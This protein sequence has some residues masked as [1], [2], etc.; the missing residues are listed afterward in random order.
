MPRDWRQL[1]GGLRSGFSGRGA[2]RPSIG[3]AFAL[4]GLHDA[5]HAPDV[6]DAKRDAV[7]AAEIEFGQAAVAMLFRAVL[8]DAHHGAL[9]DRKITFSRVGVNRHVCAVGCMGARW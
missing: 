6:I 2:V 3:E 5:A 4:S 8:T 9:E 7:V 1:R